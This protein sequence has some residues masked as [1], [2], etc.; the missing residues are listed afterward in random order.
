MQAEACLSQ[1]GS[2]SL[3]VEL[4]LRSV[5]N[6]SPTL[7]KDSMRAAWISGLDGLPEIQ[8]KMLDHTT[9]QAAELGYDHVH[10]KRGDAQQLPYEDGT[11][12][13]AYLVTV[14]GEIPDPAA[15]YLNDTTWHIGWMPGR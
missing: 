3:P 15:D 2:G 4:E 8:Q 12:D 10:P 6:I 5:Q 1:I 7:G 13:A 11:F 14:L 9:A